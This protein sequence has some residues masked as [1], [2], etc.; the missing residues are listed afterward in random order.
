MTDLT[1]GTFGA[2]RDADAPIASEL[3]RLIVGGI[4]GAV[5]IIATLVAGEYKN[6]EDAT[7]AYP[8]Y[9]GLGLRT[10]IFFAAGAFFVW[11]HQAVRTRYAVFQLGIAAPALIIAMVEAKPAE[12]TEIVNGAEVRVAYLEDAEQSSVVS[13]ALPPGMGN[14]EQSLVNSDALAPVTILFGECSIWDGL[15]GRKCD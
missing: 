5:P 14:V 9:M 11:L 4:G 10:I 2:R 8:Y 15:L 13:D 3:Q 6:F 1:E 7:D 12:P